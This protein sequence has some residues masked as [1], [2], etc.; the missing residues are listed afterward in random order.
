MT[1]RA[2]DWRGVGRRMPFLLS[3]SVMAG[4]A[5]VLKMKGWEEAGD[6]TGVQASSRYR[7]KSERR[8]GSPDVFHPYDFSDRC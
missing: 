8:R 4:C 2:V 5:Q 6:A 7:G 1:P 3:R